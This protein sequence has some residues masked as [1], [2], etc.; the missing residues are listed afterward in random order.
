[1]QHDKVPI[2]RPARLS[3]LPTLYQFAHSASY[4][5]TS[6][7]KNEKALQAVVENSL[8][9]FSPEAIENHF[10]FCLEW[11]KKVVGLSGIVVRSAEEK[12]LYA[13]RLTQET[14]QYNP[15]K[16]K[17]DQTALVLMR[18][19]KKPTEIGSLFLDRAFRGK[20]LGRLL[21][22]GRFLFMANF[23]DW[24]APLIIAELRG[25]NQEGYSPF[26]AAVGQNFCPFDFPKA[27][28]LRFENSEWIE[29]LFPKHPIYTSLLSKEAQMA[30]QKTHPS[31]TPALKMLVKQ[32]FQPSGFVDIL[33]GGP[34]LHAP[35]KEIHAIK[36]SH[37]RTVAEL[38]SSLE[39]PPSLIANLQPDFRAVQG[40]ILE[41][42]GD[43]IVLSL[44]V[45]KALNVEIGNQV[46]VY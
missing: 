21:S 13:F 19:R 35:T 23:S 8:K 26:W 31:T 17:L 36:N 11:E 41:E 4:G 5:I 30:I 40:P 27:D 20:S 1:M 14:F 6:L 44:A 18:G 38:R 24:F 33:D 39:G 7:A 16:I 29:A 45:G 42:K 2:L 32:G 10:L 25:I 37:I 15:L 34:H 43:K 12:P 9:P 28:L 22:L 46:R 3:D